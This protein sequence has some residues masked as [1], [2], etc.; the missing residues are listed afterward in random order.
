MKPGLM[1]AGAV[2][3]ILIPV[4]AACG[5]SGGGNGSASS[6]SAPQPAATGS[7]DSGNS[8][9]NGNSGTSSGSTTSAGG[10]TPPGTHLG[11]GK[12]ATVAWV[13]P[14]G[15]S[16]TGPHKG[17]KLQVTVESIQK[18]AI[19]DFKN[20]QLNA[21]EKASTPYYVKVRLKALTG[22]K[23]PSSDTDPAIT[24]D[25]IDDRGQTQGSVTF[26][27]TFQ[28]C[29][30]PSAPKPFVSG[31][32][33]EACLTYLMP[34]GGSIQ[35]VEWKDGPSKADDVSPYFEKPVVWAG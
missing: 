7:S 6:N 5:G 26:F 21:S 24:F 33:Y 23:P 16:A 10:L 31:K 18:G 27:G 2:G 9:S 34:G 13:P 20:V 1:T 17:I 25:A 29:D 19:A 30:D 22:V 4:L 11:F 3:A 15:G 8:G 12:P 14:L 28:R 32:S 35:K